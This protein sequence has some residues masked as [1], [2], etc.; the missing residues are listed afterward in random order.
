M[1]QF[2]TAY[3]YFVV[4]Y[5]RIDFYAILSTYDESVWTKLLT[6]HNPVM[7]M[8]RNCTEFQ[9]DYYGYINKYMYMMQHILQ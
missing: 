1:Q 9:Y 4:D 8:L 3:E 6:W 7:M 2:F 5:G